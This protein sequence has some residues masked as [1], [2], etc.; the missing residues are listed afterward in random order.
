MKAVILAGGSGTRLGGL[1]NKLPKHLLEIEGKSLLERSLENLQRRNISETIILAGF[2]SEKIIEQL[3]YNYNG[4]LIKYVIDVS[5]TATS[6]HASRGYVNNDTLLLCG[7]LIYEPNAIN[8]L[9]EDES[10]DAML[11][12]PVSGAKNPAYVTVDDKLNLIDIPRGKENE[13]RAYGEVADIY[14]I[15]RESLQI[16]YKIIGEEYQTGI[17]SRYIEDA[18]LGLSRMTPVKCIKRDLLWL[19][20]NTREDLERARNEIY[21]KI[22]EKIKFE[23]CS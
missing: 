19:G 21:P 7:D 14:K 1:T 23:N 5:S 22:K 10:R 9:L 12:V 4:M 16:L 6:F 11:V 17:R 20:V 8:Y 13:P 15:S 3:G 2:K 18:I